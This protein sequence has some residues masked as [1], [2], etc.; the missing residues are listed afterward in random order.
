MLKQP[1]RS[2]SFIYSVKVVRVGGE[3]VSGGKFNGDGQFDFI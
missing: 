2:T 1:C 3:D